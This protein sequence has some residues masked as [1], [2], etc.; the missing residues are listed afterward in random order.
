MGDHN[1]DKVN[2]YNIDDALYIQ[3]SGKIDPKT[4]QSFMKDIQGKIESI[5]Q[6]IVVFAFRDLVGMNSQI[7]GIFARVWLS[8][9][10]QGKSS[11]LIACKHVV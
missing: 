3:L 2:M 4:V 5:T 1:M 6:P 11:R 7:L 8:I 9:K 10:E